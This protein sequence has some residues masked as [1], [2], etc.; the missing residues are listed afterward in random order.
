V[1]SVA[2]V[3]PRLCMSAISLLQPLL[4]LPPSSSAQRVHA[5]AA[6]L[7]SEVHA[8]VDRAHLQLAAAFRYALYLFYW[9]KSTNT[10][11]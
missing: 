2:H 3:L 7:L 1:L 10:A 9:H 4:L 5:A 11:L 8:W 6:A